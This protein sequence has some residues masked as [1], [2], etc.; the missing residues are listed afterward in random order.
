VQGLIQM[1]WHGDIT[2]FVMQ[3][4]IFFGYLY[5]AILLLAYLCR[6]NHGEVWRYWLERLSNGIPLLGKARRNL[7]LGRVAAALEAELNA[8]VNIIHAWELA[9]AASGSPGLRR[10]IDEWRPRIEAGAPPSEAVLK[11][12]MFPELFANL[13]LSGEMTGQLDDTLKRLHHHYQEEGS[14]QSRAFT[15]WTVRLVFLGIMA[16]IGYEIIKF[17]AGY[18]SQFNFDDLGGGDLD[19]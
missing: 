5:G 14:R 7:A 1:V 8:G 6:S 10:T 4:G 18:A 16:G 15:Q 13:Y 12:G 17:W 2:S 19:F 9:G 11:S 3:K